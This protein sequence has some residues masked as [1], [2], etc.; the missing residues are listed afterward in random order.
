[1]KAVLISMP[2]VTPIMIHERAIHMPNHGI[3]CVAGNVDE[4]HDVF[5][6]DLNR[7]RSSIKKYLTKHLGKIRPDIVGLSSMTWQFETCMKIIR[8]VKSLLPD[9]KIVIGGYHAT[10]MYE[11][12]AESPDAGDIDFIVRGEG[13]EPFRRLMNALAGNDTFE[14]IPSLSYKKDGEFVHNDRGPNLNLAKLKMPVRDKRRLTWGYHSMF[15]RVELME[16]SRGCTRDCNFCSINHMYGRSY[17][18]YS[19]ERILADLDYLYIKKK[20]QWVFIVD[21]NMVLNP[22]WVIQV[23][24]AIADRKYKGLNLVVQADCVSM[25]KNPEMVRKMAEAGFK[26]VFMGIENGSEKNLATM[27]KG[28]IV[29]EAKRAIENCHNNGIMVIAGLIFGLPE[30]SEQEIIENYE[31]YKFL[32]ADTS[33]LQMLTPYPR[34]RIREELLKRNLVTNKNDFQWYNGLWANVRTKYL[35]SE[36]LQYFFWLHRQKVMGWWEPSTFAMERGGA[37]VRVW[38]YAIRP[39]MKFFYERK[40]RRL[41][42]E[43]RY[44]DEMLRLRLMNVFPDLEEYSRKSSSVRWEWD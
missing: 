35:T 2:D 23:C 26:S 41:G 8:L 32:E 34:T 33:Y 44:K 24:E 7:K 43:G 16:T 31:F 18:T 6:I 27:N 40:T 42:W 22:K 39:F 17:R 15:S 25:A 9:V 13:E 28:N 21:D 12:I 10:L 1:M 36:Q 29:D 20:A 38:K 5:I 4:G 19:I 14:D 37:W 3:A 11:S 30:D